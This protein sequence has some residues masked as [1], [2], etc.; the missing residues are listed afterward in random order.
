[1]PAMQ[2]IMTAMLGMMLKVPIWREGAGVRGGGE[3]EESAAHRRHEDWLRTLNERA[4]MMAR[5]K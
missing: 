4:D 3:R 5:A 1:M 2:V